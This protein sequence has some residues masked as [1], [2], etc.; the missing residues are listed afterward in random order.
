MIF[1]KHPNPGFHDR[2]W[3]KMIQLSKKHYSQEGSTSKV[4]LAF[5]RGET[6][7]FNKLG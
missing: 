4:V 3:A 1:H 7:L 2:W 5:R 6:F